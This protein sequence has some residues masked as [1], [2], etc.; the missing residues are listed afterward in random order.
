MLYP[1]LLRID[2]LEV[3]RQV[4]GLVATLFAQE[5]PDGFD[6]GDFPGRIELDDF[7]VVG[8]GLFQIVLNRETPCHAK[9]GVGVLRIQLQGFVESLPRFVDLPDA[10][11]GLAEFGLLLASA[12]AACGDRRE[13]QAHERRYTEDAHSPGT[14]IGPH[15]VS[16]F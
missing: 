1:A 5:D 6:V 9:F 16:L 8:Q 4:P 13:Q 14:G 10:E 15:N 2:L 7:A 11:E 12:A 3:H